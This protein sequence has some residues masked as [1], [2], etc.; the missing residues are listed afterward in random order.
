MSFLCSQNFAPPPAPP[1][2]FNGTCR[3]S[4]RPLMFRL[5]SCQNTLI[6]FPFHNIFPLPDFISLIFSE[7]YCI[8]CKANCKAAFSIVPFSYSS[9]HHVYEQNQS[10]ICSYLNVTFQV[11]QPYTATDK[12]TVL[13][14]LIFMF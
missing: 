11:S 4:R 1:L 13:C 9:Q 6:H 5:P 8:Y 7:R 14:V 2:K 3:F 12:I 10:T